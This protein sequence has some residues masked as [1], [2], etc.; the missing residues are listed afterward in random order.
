MLLSFTALN[1]FPLVITL[2]Y[3]DNDKDIEFPGLKQ[4]D[5]FCKKYFEIMYNPG[6]VLPFDLMQ[7]AESLLNEIYKNA[8]SVGMITSNLKIVT[9]SKP[10]FNTE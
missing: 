4:K 1:H 5:K 10:L 8:E 7:L 2:N 9:I 3:M 6:Q